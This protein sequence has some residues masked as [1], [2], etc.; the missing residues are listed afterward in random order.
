MNWQLPARTISLDRPFIMGIVN[1][2][3]DS[4]SDGGW[5]PDADAAVEYAE[6]LLDTGADCVDIGGQSTRPNNTGQV[7]VDEELGR[8]LPVI[9]TLRLSR[10]DAVISIDTVRAEV[11]QA[12]LDAGADVVNDVSGF[13]LDP[14]MARV[15]AAA[16]AGVIIM[17]SRGGISDMASYAHARYEADPVGEILRELWERVAEVR[18]AGVSAGS[19]VVDPGIGF[20]KRTETSIATLRDLPRLAS[21]GRPV[22]VGASRKRFVGELSGVPEPVARVHGSIGAH[23]AALARGARLF[24]VHD[25][26]AHREALDVAWAVLRPD[27]VSAAPARAFAQ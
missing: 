22:L 20:S 14:E 9:S 7:S 18:A 12:S 19:I 21:L 3:P 8:V 1:A 25:V 17:H 23:V 15:C 5:L 26:R 4:F 13:R 27:G 10:P 2:T 6:R 24:R 16:R 11:A